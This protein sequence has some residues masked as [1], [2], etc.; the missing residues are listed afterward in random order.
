MQDSTRMK[1]GEQVLSPNY[2]QKKARSVFHLQVVD[3]KNEHCCQQEVFVQASVT[4]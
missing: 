4:L 3:Q 1:L 2:R